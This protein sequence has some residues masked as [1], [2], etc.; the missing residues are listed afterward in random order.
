MNVT[1]DGI[2]YIPEPP[3]PKGRGLAAALE[4]RFDS[5]AGDGMTVRQYLCTLLLA[6]W[7]DPCG[8]DG[9]RPFGESGWADDLYAPLS[10][11]GFLDMGPLDDYG[12]PYRPTREQEAAADAYVGDLILAAFHGVRE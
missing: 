10:R 2:R 12:R 9:K 11:A 1:S 5:P 4:V 7:A 3:A 8:F 6:L